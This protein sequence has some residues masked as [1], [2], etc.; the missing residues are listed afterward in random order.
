MSVTLEMMDD[1][2]VITMDDGKA[3]A[4]NI[5]FLGE[6]EEALTMAEASAKAIILTGR[7]GVFSGGFDLNVFKAGDGETVAAMV[8]KG[9]SLVMRVQTSPIPVI[10]AVS[11]HALALGA[12]FLLAADTRIG[13]AGPFKFG[14]NETA[15]GLRLPAFIIEMAKQ[16]MP[17]TDVVRSV[18]QAH[19]FEGAEAINAGFLDR[20][21]EP[22]DLMSE[23]LVEARAMAA[24]DR[25]AYYDNKMM[26]RR[27]II[28]S[29]E[30]EDS[31]IG[32]N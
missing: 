8:D 3:N 9:L 1:I 18:V 25:S 4:C 2:A 14:L 28:D 29:Y 21:T 32:L 24:L 26:L 15:I 30:N 5:D 22:R 23:A 16:R 7:D 27:P 12:I 31:S 20:S 17:S 6:L 13:A 10:A 19:I 11:G